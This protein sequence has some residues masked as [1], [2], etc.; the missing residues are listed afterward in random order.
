MKILI[1][2]SNGNLGRCLVK[3]LAN[4]TNRIYE[5][6]SKPKAKQININFES[7]EN[8]K[9]PKVDLVIHC[10]RSSSSLGLSRE[11]KFLDTIFEQ[12]A[13]VVN[14]GSLSEFLIK[15]NTYGLRKS[16]I[17]KHILNKGGTVLTCGL[18]VGEN[19]KGQI[20]HLQKYLR[21]TPFY[22]RIKQNP[23]QYFT[24]LECLTKILID[25]V[26]VLKNE[27]YAMFERERIVDFNVFLKSIPLMKLA[28][29][30]IDLKKI[31]LILNELKLKFGN[32]FSADSIL[33]LLGNLDK[34][35]LHQLNYEIYQKLNKC[36]HGSLFYEQGKA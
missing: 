22:I 7:M 11:I 19:Y 34:D 25:Y 33:G 20:W 31:Y 14:I 10:A 23:Y 12:N 29:F 26:L 21:Y 5:A 15:P 28:N 16:V 30:T 35:K 27:N 17:S 4:P 8:F 36:E 9:I 1:T 3:E 13:K 2:G 32:Y 24:C 18:L 6:S